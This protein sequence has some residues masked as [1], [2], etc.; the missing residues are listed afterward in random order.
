[1]FHLSCGTRQANWG[2]HLEKYGQNNIYVCFRVAP[3]IPK[4][5][6]LTLKFLEQQKYSFNLSER[7]SV[8]R[9]SNHCYTTSVHLRVPCKYI[10]Q[11]QFLWQISQKKCWGNKMQQNGWMQ[12]VFCWVWSSARRETNYYLHSWKV[13]NAD[14]DLQ[15]ALSSDCFVM[16]STPWAGTSKLMWTAQWP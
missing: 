5:W 9:F 15:G 1:M 16:R 8:F 7:F 14:A 2:Q 12:L 11:I 13:P 10:Q 3:T 6:L 4:F